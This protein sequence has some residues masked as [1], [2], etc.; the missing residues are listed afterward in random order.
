MI[1]RIDPAEAE[2]SATPYLGGYTDFDWVAVTDDP[3]FDATEK[4][5]IGTLWTFSADRNFLFPKP[6]TIKGLQ[7]QLTEDAIALGVR[8]AGLRRLAVGDD[9]AAV[10]LVTL[11]VDEIE[12]GVVEHLR[13]VQR[14]SV[15]RVGDNHQPRIGD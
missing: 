7:V 8:H 9:A 14:C 5:A 2:A 4:P 13:L 11:G 6:D 12:Q 15:T 10:T 1:I 3:Q